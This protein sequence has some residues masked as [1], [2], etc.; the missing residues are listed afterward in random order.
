MVSSA[1]LVQL[2]AERM[3]S[4]SGRIYTVTVTCRDASNNVAVGRTTVTVPK[5]KG[6]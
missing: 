5:S 2:R 4:G 6:K 1:T 3:G